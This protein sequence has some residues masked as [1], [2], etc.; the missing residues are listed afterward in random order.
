MGETLYVQT[1]KNVKVD[2]KRITLGDV[3]RLACADK[4][5]LCRNQVR[6]I[7]NLS[8]SSPGPYSVPVIE[9]I[10]KIQQEEKNLEV[11][12]V[13]DPVLLITYEPAERKKV[14]WNWIKVIGLGILVFVGG[15]FSIMTFQTDVDTSSL[16]E[17]I[18]YHFTGNISDG[19][20]ILEITY[21]IG[22]GLGVLFYFNHLGRWKFTKDPTP[23]EVEL[24]LYEEDVSQTM[25]ES[26]TARTY[27]TEK[28]TQAD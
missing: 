16:L 12:H 14:W 5:I 11:T 22:V 17:K 3:A 13:G 7:M 26:Q 21:S 10:N 25:I 2:H 28:D 9:L 24:Y 1:K 4:H 8:D 15:A 18:Y 6:G 23:M 19:Y 27:Q 20:T